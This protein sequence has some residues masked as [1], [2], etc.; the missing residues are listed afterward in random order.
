MGKKYVSTKLK[1]N[2]SWNGLRKEFVPNLALRKHFDEDFDLLPNV[3]RSINELKGVERKT[4]KSV[5]DLVIKAA[6]GEEKLETFLPFL[7]PEFRKSKYEQVCKSIVQTLDRSRWSASHGETLKL[8]ND[9]LLQF[10]QI[11]NSYVLKNSS[12]SSATLTRVR[13]SKRKYP[14]SPNKKKKKKRKK[15]KSKEPDDTI[16]PNK[17]GP[18]KIPINDEKFLAHLNDCSEP[19]DSAKPDG[20]RHF[21]LPINVVVSTYEV[22]PFSF[23]FFFFCF[24]FILFFFSFVFFFF[25]SYHPVTSGLQMFSPRK[26]SKSQKF[27]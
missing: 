16:T 11:K 26:N 25:R 22:N 23:V 19:A 27:K 20:D 12:I 7:F 14:G 6:G 4:L 9:I 2:I 8:R 1:A 18:K 5:R 13:N 15:I 3:P 24:F 10:D 17:R 21:Y